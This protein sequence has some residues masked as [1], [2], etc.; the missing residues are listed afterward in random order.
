AGV[1]P[2]TARMGNRLV[3]GY[4]HAETI[5]ASVIGPVGTRLRGHEF[6]YSRCEPAGD[7]VRLSSRFGTGSD[8]F[9]TPTLLATY[10]HHHAGGDP[11]IV[12]A[13]ARTCAL[14]RSAARP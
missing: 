6:H 9:A 14:G 2:A 5:T 1:V 10:L 3:L 13:F 8:G 4:R 12:A 7:A 11:S